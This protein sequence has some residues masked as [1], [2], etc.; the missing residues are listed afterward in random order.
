LIGSSCNIADLS[1]FYRRKDIEMTHIFLK[2]K[3]NPRL[4]S[5]TQDLKILQSNEK[6]SQAEPSELAK[7]ITQDTIPG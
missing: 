5:L 3:L 2:K 6:N 4:W 1:Y 7:S